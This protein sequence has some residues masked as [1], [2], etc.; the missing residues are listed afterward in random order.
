MKILIVGDVHWST[1]SSI[2]RSRGKY[3]STRLENLVASINWAECKALEFNCERVV[4]LGD[5]FDKPDL[6]SEELTALSEIKWSNL[7]HYFLVGNHEASVKSL[8]YN[9]VEAL[10]KI[11]NMMI[12]RDISSL[13]I[14]PETELIFI[15]YITED[16]RKP[17]Q[18]YIPD[19]NVKNK[20]I[21]SHNDIKGLQLGMF[22]SKDGFE[23]EEIENNCTCFL[24]GHIH[25]GQSFCKNGINLGNLTGQNFGE[26]AFKYNH[27][28]YIL[29]T[30]Q[31][32]LSQIENPHAFNFYQFE[33]NAIEDINKLY[34][35]RNNAVVSIKTLKSLLSEVKE[36]IKTCTNIVESRIIIKP[37]IV[38]SEENVTLQKLNNVD[39]LV[40]FSICVKE[41][42]GDTEEVN[43][44]LSKILR[45]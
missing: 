41:K 36:K 31:L 2:V 1:Y 19:K 7:P 12:I 32:V 44:E 14:T 22:Q 45:R 26:N 33:I 3:Y 9:S 23:I 15:P 40:Q 38:K 28:A 27:S 20:I 16:D 13:K 42:L 30:D 39:H 4:Y 18:D 24:N 37:E 43:A 35:L 21:F 25:N 17:L 10:R 11:P 8:I 6:T 5:F 29:D 34:S